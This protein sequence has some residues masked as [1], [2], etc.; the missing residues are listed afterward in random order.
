M[1]RKIRKQKRQTDFRFETKIGGDIN[2]CISINK[3]TGEL[4][5]HYH[6][7]GNGKPSKNQKKCAQTSMGM[8]CR[9][10]L[11]EICLIYGFERALSPSAP[12]K[13]YAKFI[14]NQALIQSHR[15]FKE[16]LP[17]GLDFLQDGTNNGIVQRTRLQQRIQVSTVAKLATLYNCT[18]PKLGLCDNVIVIILT[19]A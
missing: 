9:N 2:F 4:Q 5:P 7:T 6:R 18:C 14:P 16:T 8:H 13:P 11:F 12:S 10:G 17:D 15:S 3:E 19:L 1:W